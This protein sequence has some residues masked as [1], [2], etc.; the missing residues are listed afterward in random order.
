MRLARHGDTTRVVYRFASQPWGSVHAT[1]PDASGMP[2]VQLT[3][4]GGGVLG[5][6][7]LDLDVVLEPGAHA[8]VCTQGAT[9]AYRGA[10]AAQ[11]TRLSAARG[12]VLEYV[13]HHVI[14]FAGA[15]WHQRTVIDLAADARLLAWDALAAGRVARGERFAFE[16]LSGR[17]V[18]ERDGLP[19]AVDGCE[20]HGG[21]EAFAGFSYLATAYVAAPEG[22]SA[23]ADR[24]HEAVGA[25]P[26]TLAAASHPAEGLVV[27]RILARTAP[28]LGRALGAVRTVGRAALGLG[29]APREVW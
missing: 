29:P 14:P 18:I 9:K 8:T 10:R 27:T 22:L 19:L 2:E 26:G 3:N 17:T 1:R 23:V 15:H 12:A 28:A 6:D 21:R 11:L 13:P 20:L 7:R 16:R 24:I 5:G 25:I 4:P